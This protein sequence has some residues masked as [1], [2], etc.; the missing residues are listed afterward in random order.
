MGR[1]LESDGDVH[2]IFHKDN[3]G[4]FH[5]EVVQDVGKYLKANSD[6]FNVTEKGTSW[7][8]DFHKVASIPEVVAAQWWKELGSNPFSKENRGWLAAKLNSR[9]FYKLRTRAGNI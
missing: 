6:E 1:L 8:G 3:S 7:K 9:E 4:G 2:E 5:I